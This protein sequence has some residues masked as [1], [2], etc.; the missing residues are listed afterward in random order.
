MDSLQG[1]IV[2]ASTNQMGKI[3]TRYFV[4][5]CALQEK[6]DEKA[7]AINESISSYLQSF[8]DELDRLITDL[9]KAVGVPGTGGP[10]LMEGEN[11]GK[12]V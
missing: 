5:L 12:A 7:F 2:A 8:Y 11:H 1:K 9:E 4:A 10:S 6:P 3:I